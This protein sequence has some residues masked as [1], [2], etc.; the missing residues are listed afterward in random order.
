MIHS[1][2]GFNAASAFAATHIQFATVAANNAIAAAFGATAAMFFVM[3]PGAEKPDPGMMVN[4]MLTISVHGVGGLFGVLCMGI[5]ADGNYGKGWNVLTRHHTID[6]GVE[7][8][9]KGKFGQLAS[10][11]IGVVVLCTVVIGIAYAF[12]SLQNKLTKGGIRYEEADEMIGLDIPE[13]GVLAYP[14]FE[15]PASKTSVGVS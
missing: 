10:Q 13:M 12:F 15:M 3:F 14:E 2:L 6:R 8:V 1:T 4:G 5:F 11:A 9:V 7:A